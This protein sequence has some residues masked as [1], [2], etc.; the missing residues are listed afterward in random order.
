METIQRSASAKGLVRKVTVGRSVDGEDERRE[1]DEH[2]RIRGPDKAT[3]RL[4][5]MGPK[6]VE[7]DC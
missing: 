6:A 2:T 4:F 7:R 1:V 3:A 5:E